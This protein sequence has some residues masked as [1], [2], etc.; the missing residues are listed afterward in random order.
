MTAQVPGHTLGP[1]APH[2][3]FWYGD[4]YIGQTRGH[5]DDVEAAKARL[6][7]HIRILEGIENAARLTYMLE[8][9]TE[10]KV[11]CGA[12]V[13][14]I[15]SPVR[16]VDLLRRLQQAGYATER[17][18]DVGIQYVLMVVYDPIRDLV[19]GLQKLR[20]PAFLIGKLTFPGGRLEQGERAEDA[21]SRELME[22]AGVA[23]SVDAWQF[24]CR[25]E[26]MV[27][28]AV[29]TDDILRAHQ[30][31]DEPVFVMNVT[32]QLEYAARIPEQYA[33]DFIITLE[34]SLATLG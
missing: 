21:A 17:H 5:P 20:G 18:G 6:A 25:H 24:V 4:T 30:C 19:V 31:E 32:R 34:A 9:Y 13:E 28:L 8:H 22:E 12:T 2:I 23:V 7:R 26:S 14:P 11:V 15:K 1:A 3:A 27:V 29:T 10:A 33:P 16:S